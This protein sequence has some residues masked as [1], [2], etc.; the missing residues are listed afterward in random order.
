MKTRGVR[1]YGE[2]DIRLEEFELPEIKDD[3]ILAL[4]VSNSI[5]MSTYKA[6]IQGARHKRV[7]DDVA[8]NPTITGHEFAGEIVEVGAKWQDQFKVGQ[9]FAIQPALNYKGSPYAPGYSYKYFGGNTEYTIIPSEVMELGY[10]L[11]YQGEAF[12]EASLAEPMSCIIGGYRAVYHTEINNYVHNL[13]IIDKGKTALLGAAGPMGLG[14]IDY[15]LHAERRPSL[16]VVTDIN[17]ARLDRAAAL[18]PAEEAVSQGVE[19]H[20]VNTQV[21]D[22]ISFLME[23]T[24]GT[25]FDDVFVYAPVKSLVE[26]GDRILGNDGCLNFFA[27]PIDKKFAA[28]V[29]FYNIHYSPTHI[30]GST[31]GNDNDMR[32]SLIM[33][34]AGKINP[35]IMITHVGG[36]NS[37]VDT[38]KNLPDIPGGKKLIYTGIDMELTAISDFAA[39]AKESPL[40]AELARI[41]EKNKGLW[42]V[43]AEKYLLHYKDK[44]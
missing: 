39:K 24:G 26:Q 42:S 17:Q 14:A 38:I 1:L 30:M 27:G 25:G 22:A 33:S 23:L 3:E 7:P 40:F 11:D 18:F 29:N 34:A 21:D 8:E 32:E 36:I 6:V 44:K 9:K 20:F 35:A 5:C 2:N 28:E 16:L 10:L 12:Y 13:G 15:V 19:L 31:G 41:I 4:V 37:A 43:E